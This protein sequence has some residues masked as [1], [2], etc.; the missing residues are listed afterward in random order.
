MCS[1]K[2]LQVNQSDA[3]TDQ[4]YVVLCTGT[5]FDVKRLS[6]DGDLKKGSEHSMGML[7]L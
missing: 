3:F 7:S 2:K 6:F 4:M 1:I 5:F